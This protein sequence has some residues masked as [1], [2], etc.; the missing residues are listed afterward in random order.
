MIANDSN[1]NQGLDMSDADFTIEYFS[2]GGDEPIPGLPEE[3][4]YQSAIVPF[5]LSAPAPNP[6][7][8]YTTI[9]FG[10]KNAGAVSL[11][12]FDITGRRI[13]TFYNY[14]VL[15]PGRYT[16]IWD[17]VCDHGLRVSSGVYFIKYEAGEFRETRKLI[18][19][20]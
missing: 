7:N 13:K 10:V 5:Y 14:A 17:G 4:F 1:Q 9:E 6:F 18:L 15:S 11:S 8:P 16:E 3:E 2:K 19:L 20:K 12:I